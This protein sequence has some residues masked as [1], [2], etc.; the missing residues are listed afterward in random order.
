MSDISNIINQEEMKKLGKSWKTRLLEGI[1]YT[2]IS[3]FSI[4]GC[5]G[6]TNP[7]DDSFGEDEASAIAYI[8]QV[9]EDNGYSHERDINA[10]FLDPDSSQYFDN[11]YDVRGELSSD[12]IYIEY[13]STADGLAQQA[14]DGINA[15]TNAAYPPPLVIIES[16]DTKDKIKQKINN[17]LGI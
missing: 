11:E 3:A 4:A 16:T 12:E 7:I 9:L 17:S 13:R 1:A 8:E 6:K 2:A 10:E 14:E 5:G 15:R